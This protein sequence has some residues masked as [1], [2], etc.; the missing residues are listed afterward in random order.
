MGMVVCM[1]YMYETRFVS[2]SI[3]AH[4]DVLLL[5]GR[6]IHI[7]LLFIISSLLHG[8]VVWWYDMVGTCTTPP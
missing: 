7:P 5:Q 2:S 8:M 6:R 3:I 4:D 1:Y